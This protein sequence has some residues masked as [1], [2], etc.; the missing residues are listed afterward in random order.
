MPIDVT[1]V[2]TAKDLKAF[3][4]LPWRLYRGDPNWVPPL[5]S[6]MK[7]TLTG[8]G[9]ANFNAG[10]HALALARRTADGTAD[11][12]GES[13]R[14]PASAVGNIR[15]DAAASGRTRREI[16]G[17]TRREIAGRIVV[18]LNDELSRAKGLR[19]GYVCLFESVSD[20]EVARALFDWAAAWLRVRGAVR[21]KGPISPT[22]GDDYRGLLVMGFDG[23]PV[24][25]DSYNPPYYQEFFERYGF[26]KDIDLFAYRYREESMSDRYEK[27]ASYA[28]RRYGFRV[29]SLDLK[30]LDR[31]IRDIKSVLD[32]AMPGEWED[33]TP[34]TLRDLQAMARRLKPLADPDLCPIAR[35]AATN[36]PIGFVVSLPDYNQVLA[37]LNGRLSPLG[38]LRF[39]RYRRRI[40][41]VRLFV[42]FVVPEWRKKGVTG[43]IFLHALREARRKGYKWGEGST[44]GETNLPMRR[45]AER[46]GGEHYRTYRIYRK[47]L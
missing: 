5:I 29:D 23:R 38:L 14:E 44:I 28:M 16:A 33:M 10:P 9:N 35:V 7:A 43:A 8:S 41:G 3:I 27:V 13:A 6:D 22:N 15:K 4:L 20:Y 17:R 47:D 21:V 2:K 34:P 39:F 26:S 12:V 30:Q 36:E 32:R 1:E 25:M 19:T 42:L 11:G 45:D 37:G 46:A 18:G 40:D 31:D 24:L